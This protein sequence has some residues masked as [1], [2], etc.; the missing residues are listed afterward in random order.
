M[1]YL[2]KHE[3]PSSSL[4]RTP[5]SLRSCLLPTPLRVLS[6]PGMPFST[7][8]LQSLP[9]EGAAVPDA[10]ACAATWNPYYPYLQFYPAPFNNSVWTNV[11]QAGCQFSVPQPAAHGLPHFT[12][13]VC[14]NPAWFNGVAAVASGAKST[15]PGVACPTESA[16]PAPSASAASGTTKTDMLSAMVLCRSWLVGRLQW[17]AVRRSHDQLF[18]H[19]DTPDNNA[20]VPF[21]FS[22]ENM[23]RVEAIKALYPVGYT[24][25]AIL[26]VLDLAQRQHGWLP[27]SAMNKVADVIGVPKMRI[28]E[29]ATFYTMYN[30]QKVGKY[31]VQV[32]TTTPCMLRGADQILKHVKKECLGSDAVGETSQDFMFTVSEVE[33]L[34]ACAN[35]PMMQI[36]DD[37]YE[38]LTYDDVTRIFGEIRAGKKPKMGPQSGRLAAEPISG[39]TSLT[40]T[41]YGP[42]FKVQEN[43]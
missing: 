11:M 38:D 16:P 14:V 4:S 43:L 36:N 37:Y 32:C 39:L 1:R 19:R 2:R 34:G 26:P 18:V 21:E 5:S 8:S 29:V 17:A 9:A 12:Y 3:A 41:P 30:R 10:G 15:E 13:P 7:S 23:K 27:I 24:S 35:A 6:A 28:Y 25:A 31:H 33:C 40:S 20:D 22:E 42:G